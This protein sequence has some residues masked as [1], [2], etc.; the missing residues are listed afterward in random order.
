VTS[1]V[2]EMPEK[3]HKHREKWQ[4]R[5]ILIKKAEVIGDRRTVLHHR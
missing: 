4:G 3:L 1:L 2:G 5:S